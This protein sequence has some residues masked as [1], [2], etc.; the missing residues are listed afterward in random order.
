VEGRGPDV[1]EGGDQGVLVVEGRGTGR[2]QVVQA[3][4]EPGQRA[5]QG[6]DVLAGQPLPGTRV[7]VD[8]G[9]C[10]VGEGLHLLRPQ[11][12]QAR[13]GPPVLHDGAQDRRALP[14][15]LGARGD[16]GAQR[17]RRVGGDGQPGGSG[18]VAAG[19]GAPDEFGQDVVLAVE[20]EVEAAAGDAGHGEDVADGEVAELTVGE[21]RGGGGQ[22]GLAQVGGVAAARGP[23][24]VRPG[25][26]GG[27]G[28]CR[29]ARQPT[30]HGVYTYCLDS[31]YSVI[32]STL[33]CHLVTRNPDAA[34]AWYTS[35]LGATEASRITLPGG[36]VLT[37]E[38]ADAVWQRAL[39]D[40]ATEFEPLHDAFWGDRTGQFID[41]FGHRW[42]IDQ[43]I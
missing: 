36:Q 42:A 4:A 6:R 30:R 29:H 22:D 23:A 2:G 21:Q 34:A 41:P 3:L 16:P 7:G 11:R 24:P 28:W 8:L 31:M 33:T 19:D 12:L 37:I 25:R 20:V 10:G 27:P 14:P 1:Q 18:V 15:Q 32:M 5:G 39:A 13:V 26:P 43:H 35:V 40:G 9:H 17:G 38:D